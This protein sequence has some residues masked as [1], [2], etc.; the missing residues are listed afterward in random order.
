MPYNWIM[1]KNKFEWDPN[2]QKIN[3]EK[4]GIDFVDVA[5]IFNDIN[6]IETTVMNESGEERYITIGTVN[7]IILL[8]V[9]T[10]R[11]NSIRL[12]SA[13]RASKNERQYYKKQT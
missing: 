3:I 6:R 2:K 5:A 7:N 11:G 13:R 9:Y 1:N 10:L 8:V 12:I 4:H